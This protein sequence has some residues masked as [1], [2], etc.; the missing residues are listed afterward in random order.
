[1]SDKIQLETL[2]IYSKGPLFRVFFNPKALEISGNT[3]G[4]IPPFTHTW[5]L[6]GVPRTFGMFLLSL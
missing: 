2:V 1:M 6:K 4:K 5:G 3:K